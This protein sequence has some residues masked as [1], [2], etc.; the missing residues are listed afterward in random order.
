MASQR[1]RRCE[2]GKND[3]SARLTSS[4]SSSAVGLA[5]SR[6]GVVCPADLHTIQQSASPFGASPSDVNDGVGVCDSRS[7]FLSTHLTVV[8]YADAVLGS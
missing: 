7:T 3:I 8:E 6:S 1:Q 2:G 5:P 4:G